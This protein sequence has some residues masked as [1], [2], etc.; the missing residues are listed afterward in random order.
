[1]AV[2][3]QTAKNK[4]GE[5]KPGP[6]RPKGIPNRTTTA[7]KDMILNALDKSGG[8]NYLV[9]QA[10]MNPVAFMSLIGKVLPMQVTGE[11]GGAITVTINKPA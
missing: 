2:V 6:G 9:Q 8:E 3:K 4:I 7:L 10:A 11:N 5:G 1:M